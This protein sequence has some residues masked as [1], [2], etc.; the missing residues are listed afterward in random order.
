MIVDLARHY[1][2]FFS[3]LSL[4]PVAFFGVFFIY[5]NPSDPDLEELNRRAREKNNQ[6]YN[7]WPEN[8]KK[9][10]KILGFLA[11]AFIIWYFFFLLLGK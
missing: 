9:A 7:D 5:V 8:L 4:F 1:D 6:Y 2:Y 10:E 3:I 11:F